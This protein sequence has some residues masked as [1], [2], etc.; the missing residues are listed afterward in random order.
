MKSNNL[1]LRELKQLRCN[2]NGKR[3]LISKTRILHVHQA[4][5][6]ISLPLLH[7]NQMIPPDATIC[8]GQKQATTIFLLSAIECLENKIH[9]PD[10]S[11]T[12]DK[13]KEL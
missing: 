11:L 10:N 7:D 3:S 9:F 12:I 8:R 13:V 2:K 4:L 6:Y 1:V 5:G